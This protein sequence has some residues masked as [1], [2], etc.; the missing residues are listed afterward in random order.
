MGH[1]QIQSVTME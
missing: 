1:G